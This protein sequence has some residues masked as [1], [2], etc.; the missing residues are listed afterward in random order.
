MHSKRPGRLALLGLAPVIDGDNGSPPNRTLGAVVLHHFSSQ[1]GRLAFLRLAAV[2]EGD[3]GSP[4]NRVPGA[5]VLHHLVTSA[6][7]HLPLLYS[8]LA[9]SQCSAG[10]HFYLASLP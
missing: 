7:K 5:V 3:N 1:T 9:L 10:P 2:I 8:L 6:A 4:P